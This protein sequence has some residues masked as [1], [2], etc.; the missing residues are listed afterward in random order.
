[1]DTHLGVG[2]ERVLLLEV[3]VEGGDVVV[4]VAVGAD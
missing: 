2:L 3:R 1:V 4:L